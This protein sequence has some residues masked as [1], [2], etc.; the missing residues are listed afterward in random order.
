REGF[1]SCDVDPYTASPIAVWH[2]VT[3][4]DGTYDSHM[5]YLPYH[6]TGANWGIPF[7][8]I[9]NPE[10][11]LPY[12]GHY[13]DEFI[14]PQ[15]HIGPSP[16]SD[17]R[18]VHVYGNNYTHTNYNSIYLYADFDDNDLMMTSDLDWTVQSFPYFDYLTYNDIARINKDMI[19]SEVDG[20]VVFFG[21]VADSLFTLY[22]DDYGETFTK[23]TYQLL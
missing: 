14:W 6:E 20:K 18:R 3:E 8:V 10:I 19:V 16:I 7:I 11:G 13:D 17:H 5:S 22:S 1:T 9:D 15:V 2:A 12:T 21:N 4:P 23:Y